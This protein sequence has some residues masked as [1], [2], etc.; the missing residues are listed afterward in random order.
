MSQHLVKWI[1]DFLGD[2]KLERPDGRALYAYRCSRQEF[3]SLA[4]MLANHPPYVTRTADIPARAFVLYAA[5]WWQREYDGG[6]WAWEPLLESIG[7]E[8]VHYPDLYEPI[9]KAWTW[10]RIGLVRLPTSVRY[11]G[12]FACQGGLPLAFV[13]DAHSS[14]TRYL[15]AVLKHVDAYRRFVDDPIVLAQDQQ[16]LLRPPTLRRDYV[17]RLA[18]DL[19]EYVLELQDDTLT[20]NPLD[21]LDQARPDWRCTMPLALEDE[22]T[23]DLL[24]GLLQEAARTQATPVDEFRV[25]RFLRR[26]GTGWRMGARI[27]LPARI[28]AE[29]LARQ[30]KVR[31]DELQPRLKVRASGE[32]TRTL[33]LYAEQGDDFLLLRDSRSITELWDFEA[34]AEVRLEFL[35][36]GIVGE[37]LVPNRGSAL[38]DLPWAFRGSDDCSLIGEGS[39]ANRSPTILVLVPDGCIPSQGD[40]LTAPE[41]EENKELRK[42]TGDSTNTR[43]P[44]LSLDDLRRDRDQNGKRAMRDQTRFGT[45]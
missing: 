14:V 2:R 23:R 4:S 28:S 13:G 32:N 24:T 42:S 36:G 1:K 39:V 44:P 9:K 15:R 34:T 45:C 22:R 11:L 38:S 33:G 6:T 30:I 12:T 10:W 21:A 5:E 18:A 20:D 16:H 26:T 25:E 17:F 29:I 40:A 19:V 37:S 41:L 43:P 27:R 3:E 31:M 8:S 7:W 35:A